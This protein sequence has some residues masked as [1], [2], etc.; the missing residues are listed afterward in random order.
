MREYVLIGPAP[1]EEQCIQVGDPDHHKRAMI[2]CLH[3]VKG[4]RRICGEPP[5]GASLGVKSFPHDY[6]S[7]LECVVFLP[8][9][10]VTGRGF[11]LSALITSTIFLRALVGGFMGGD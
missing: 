9:S 4:I 11:S 6:G 7:Y 2:E 10:G 3:F 1:Q 8:S 5:E